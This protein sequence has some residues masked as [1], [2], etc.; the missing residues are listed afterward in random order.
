MFCHRLAAH[1]ISF[2]FAQGRPASRQG[3]EM[4]EIKSRACT[5]RLNERAHATWIDRLL[6]SG[7][8]IQTEDSVVKITFAFA[9]PEAAIVI[10]LSSQEVRH[11]ITGIAED[12]R[13]QARDLEHFE[14][15]AHQ[16]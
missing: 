11:Q 8:G 6:E 10:L 1:W 14:P 15:N 7:E 2:F 9:V 13:R 16:A 12:L 4:N 3:A 5:E